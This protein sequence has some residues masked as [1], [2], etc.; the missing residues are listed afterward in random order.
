MEHVCKE[1]GGEIVAK[2]TPATSPN[3]G[4]VI[5]AVVLSD[6]EKGKFALKDK[7]SAMASA[8]GFLRERGAFP[9]DTGDDDDDEIC[10]GDD[11]FDGIDD[12]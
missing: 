2:S 4:F 1:V 12:M 7:D 5:S 6:K 10:F 11:A 8:F 9:E 3:K